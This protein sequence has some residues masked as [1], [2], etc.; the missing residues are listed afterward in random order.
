MSRLEVLLIA[1]N[2][3]ENKGNIWERRREKISMTF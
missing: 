2:G 1:F 3:K